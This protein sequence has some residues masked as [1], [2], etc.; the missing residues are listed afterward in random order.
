[1][2]S[3][4]YKRKI[5]KKITINCLINSEF[6][7][8]DDYNYLLLDGEKIYRFNLMCNILNIEKKGSITNILVDDGTGNIVVRLFEED[9]N[10]INI[11][12][13]IIIIG[14]LRKYYDEKY[15]SPEIVKKINPLWL[16]VRVKE[17]KNFNFENNNIKFIKEEIIEDED[18]LLPFEILIKLINQLD[19]GNG[20]AIETILEKSTLKETEKLIE[21]MLE[22]GD[23]F[24]NS[25]GKIKVL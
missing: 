9:N 3:D 2:T 5:A 21:K 17:L 20:V 6:V 7:Q 4:I 11:G 23:L 10:T 22:K 19:K 8:Q 12:D 15:I 14:K 18:H 1:M 13:T 25:P 24:Q 16:K